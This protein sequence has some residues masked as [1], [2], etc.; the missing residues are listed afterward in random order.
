MKKRG[1]RC[2]LINFQS[3]YLDFYN[4]YAINNCFEDYVVL[5]DGERASV[6][7]L[8]VGDVWSEITVSYK[9][10]D[11]EDGTS[12]FIINYKKGTL[13]IKPRENEVQNRL[14]MLEIRE[15]LESKIPELSKFLSNTNVYEIG[16]LDTYEK[17][18]KGY[19]QSRHAVEY[20]EKHPE[21]VNKLA[22]ISNK[23]KQREDYK[24]LNQIPTVEEVIESSKF[25]YNGEEK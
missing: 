23:A 11:N 16:M 12:N 9:G 15:F 8:E 19:I 13:E 14:S 10:S 2:L 7:D 5:K 17:Y 21:A 20:E 25:R 6:K 1:K 24:W 18:K 4:S 22:E 3:T